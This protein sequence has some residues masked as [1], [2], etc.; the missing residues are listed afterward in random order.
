MAKKGWP[1]SGRLRQW[2][3]LLLSSQAVMGAFD[4]DAGGKPKAILANTKKGYGVPGYE[5]QLKSHFAHLKD[6]E[7]Q[8]AIAAL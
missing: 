8:Q 3:W 6:E 1:G 4:Q 5:C 2:A 7:Y